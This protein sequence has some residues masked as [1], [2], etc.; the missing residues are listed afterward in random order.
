MGFT[1]PGTRATD[2]FMT[3]AVWNAE[4]VDNMNTAIEHLLVRKP[5]DEPL[6]SNTTLQN[7]DH[8]LAA[9]LANEAWQ[10]KLIVLVTG[11]TTGNI[12]I[13]FTIPSGTL[14]MVGVAKDASG[15]VVQQDFLSSGTDVRNFLVPGA[16][17]LPIVIQGVVVCGGTP[18]NFQMQWA[19]NVSNA[20]TTNV[21]AN[22]TLWGVKLA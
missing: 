21:K 12:K 5:S 1:A 13:A 16:T 11:N 20:T 6:T 3:A 14:H 22:S 18:G 8:L 10:F 4:I 7:D 9:M 15:T 19:Q 17:A 2:Y